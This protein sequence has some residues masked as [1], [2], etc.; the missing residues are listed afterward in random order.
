[1]MD[2]ETDRRMSGKRRGT[3][4]SDEYILITRKTTITIYP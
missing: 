1:M 4:I 2:E 3:I